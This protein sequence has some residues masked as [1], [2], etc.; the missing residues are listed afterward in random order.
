MAQGLFIGLTSDTL[1]ALEQ[2]LSLVRVA[3][4]M[5]ICHWTPPEVCVCLHGCVF[6]R[7]MGILPLVQLEIIVTGKKRRLSEQ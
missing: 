2:V 7:K 1:W 3:A 6:L 5:R 4:P